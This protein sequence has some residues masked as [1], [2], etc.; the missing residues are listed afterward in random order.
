MYLTDSVHPKSMQHS[1]LSDAFEVWPTDHGVHAL[2][3]D[4]G[5]AQLLGNLH[6]YAA[7]AFVI[8]T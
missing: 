7:Q 3:H 6:R 4:A 2:L 8:A 1:G 5:H